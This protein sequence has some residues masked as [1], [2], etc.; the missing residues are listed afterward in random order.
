MKY[1]KLLII[2]LFLIAISLLAAGSVSAQDNGTDIIESDSSVSEDIISDDASDLMTADQ[3][4]DVISEDTS[5]EVIAE[6]DNGSEP[7]AYEKFLTDIN[8]GVKEVE[9]TGDIS[10]TEQINIYQDITINGNNHVIDG[11]N[12]SEGIFNIHS[13]VI[14]KN[15]IFKNAKSTSGSAIY[16]KCN[17]L[18]IDNCQ[19]IN[20]HADGWGGAI[21]FKAGKLEITNSK[22]KDNSGNSKCGGAIYANDQNT[23]IKGC[24]FEGNTLKNTA[25]AEGGAIYCWGNSQ[26]SNCN[27]KNNKVDNTKVSSH[28]QVNSNQ[29]NGG[30]I[31][32]YSGTHT[33][34]GCTFT[35]NVADNHGGAIFSYE[36]VD[37]LTVNKCEFSKNLANFED[38]GAI[39]STGKKLTVK[40]SKFNNNEAYED[41]GAIDTYS[42]ANYS[43]VI[44]IKDSKFNSNVAYKGAGVIW[45]GVKTKHTIT[46]CQFTSNKASV[47][48][49]LYLEKSTNV[50]IN[51]CTFSKNKAGKIT[52]K[53]AL[54]KHGDVINPCGG[55]VYVAN[56]ATAKITNTKFQSNEAKYGAG[57][58]N[59][60]T[61]TSVSKCTFSSNHASD[62]GAGVFNKNKMTISSSTFSSNKAKYGCGLFND[63]TATVTSSKFYSNSGSS[64]AAIFNKGTLTVKSSTLNS[65]KADFGAA[66]YNKGT[67]SLS[68][69]TIQYNKGT[70]GGALFQDSGKYTLT[71]NLITSNSASKAG[72][73]LY[74]KSGKISTKG[75]VFV[76]NKAKYGKA[77]YSKKSVSLDNNW[78][79]NTKKNMKKSPTKAKL[80]NIKVKKWLYLK[81]TSSPAKVAKGKKAKIS[82]D[83]RY[84]NKNKKIAK[85][86]KLPV[87]LTAKAGKLSSKN[88]KLSKG[89]VKVKFKKTGKKGVV[90]AKVLK[91][92]VSIKIK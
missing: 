74:F 13:N 2:S 29:A 83:L 32:F 6:E 38:G 46:N 50:N 28:S 55:A 3:S 43:P 60:G 15:I 19:F 75:N 92:K 49:C 61:K 86:P 69:N 1:K 36:N 10:P 24:T 58:Y 7:S 21:Y 5:E 76:S 35:S 30:A 89:L 41:G 31:Y 62:S 68:Y 51:K 4:N 90:K 91:S 40:N 26:I 42:M 16:A 80:A 12:S 27:F 64:G 39:S 87:S 52:E 88:V 84:N 79:G 78:W 22:F 45:C 81:I 23:I 72:G 54:S 65:N 47:G 25:Q 66:V 44:T 14:L 11:S 20:N 48:G 57:I 77:V 18:K 73:A 67:A 53:T 59:G 70:S 85:S 37:S 71:G 63:K 34:T 9:L 56:G 82:V 17:N 8:N 33:V